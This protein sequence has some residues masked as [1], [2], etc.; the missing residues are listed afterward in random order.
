MVT[1]ANKSDFH[2]LNFNAK[3]DVGCDYRAVDMS[4]VSAGDLC[5]QCSSSLRVT[6]GIEIGNIFQ[7]GTKY[8]GSMG[9]SFLDENGKSQVPTMGCYGIGVGRL[10]ASIIEDCHDGRGPVWPWAVAPYQ[11][12]LCVLGADDVSSRAKDVY[13][14]LTK[15]GIEVL[16]DDTNA[17]A[18]VQF[19]DADLIGA[20]LRFV[21]S[22]RNE[23]RG[24]I[25]FAFRDGSK[26]GEVRATAIMDLLAGFRN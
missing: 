14:E 3:R 1:G 26:K 13:E 20:P 7:L 5:S 17:Q 6:R 25:E 21:I 4:A 23:K 10:M 2:L 12:H 11:V 24:V 19:A 16:W 8:T 9:M 22:S 18:G 15:H